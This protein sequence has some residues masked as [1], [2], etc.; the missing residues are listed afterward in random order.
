MIAKCIR[1][2]PSAFVALLAVTASGGAS[3]MYVHDSAGTLGTVE[4]ETGAVNVLGSM[5]EVMTD[6]AFDTSGNLFGIT[7]SG[8][9]SIDPTTASSSFIGGHGVPGGNALVFDTDGT[10]Y[11]AGTSS[12]DLFSIDPSS[13]STTSLGTT[14]F[15]SGGDLAFVGDSFYLAD[16]SSRLVSLNL[17]DLSAS[18]AVG[19]FGVSSVFG[20]ATDEEDTMFGV[21]GTQIFTVDTATGGALNS[22]NYGGQGLGTAFG[23]SFFAEAGAPGPGP[24]PEPTPTPSP[25]PLPASG[26]LLLGAFG[27]SGAFKLS[28]KRS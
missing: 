5:G 2:V 24:G 27:M 16:S 10:L 26:L 19:S 14:G 7:F 22:I 6:I 15:S 12:R 18:T 1:T 13:G 3:T 11:S 4:T 9:Y 28:R 25:I 8:L 21:G 20:I 17:A 23:Q